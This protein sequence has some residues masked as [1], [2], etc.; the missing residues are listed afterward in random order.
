[1]SISLESISQE[2]LVQYQRLFFEEICLLDTAGRDSFSV[3]LP[4]PLDR[5][6]FACVQ[7]TVERLTEE[8]HRLSTFQWR[9]CLFVPIDRNTRPNDMYE[10]VYDEL[11]RRHP[12][13]FIR[14]YVY[15]IFVKVYGGESLDLGIGEND[16]PIS[17]DDLQIYA[18]NTNYEVRLQG[19]VDLFNLL[20]SKQRDEMRDTGFKPKASNKVFVV[21][22]P[23]KELQRIQDANSD[24]I[25]TARA[26]LGELDLIAQTEAKLRDVEAALDRS[27]DSRV[28][29]EGPARSGKTVIAMNLLSRYPDSKM[30]L[31]NWYFYDALRDAFKIWGEMDADE[32]R[33][34]FS[35]DLALLQTVR[36][37]EFAKDSLTRFARDPKLLE[38]EIKMREWPIGKLAVLPK[39]IKREDEN[40][41]EWLLSN[42]T[43]SDAGNYVFVYASSTKT[44]RP[45]RLVKVHREDF[46]AKAEWVYDA[47][48]SDRHTR[49]LDDPDG[50]ERELKTLLELRKAIEESTVDELLAA[51]VKNTAD[52]LSLSGQR[53]FHHDR[54]QDEGLWVDGDQILIPGTDMIIC[55]EA[56]RLGNY[57]G[58]DEVAKLANRPG[59]LFLCGDDCQRLNKAGD[60]GILQLMQSSRGEFKT[61]ELPESVGIPAEVGML[62]RSLLGECEAPKVS[63]SF[64]VKLISNNDLALVSAFGRDPSYKK[65]YAIPNST[66]FYKREYTPGITRSKSSTSEC[67]NNC[68]DHCTHRFIPMLSQELGS[69]FKFF[70]AEAI[71]PNYALSAYELISR[72]V[73][74]VYLKIPES[75]DARILSAPLE[76]G[77]LLNSWIKRHLYVLMTR[78]TVQLVI[79][80]E[81]LGLYN[82]FRQICRQA[83][84]D[85]DI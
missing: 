24:V 30:L 14:S 16:S 15:V 65:H 12:S 82:H 51:L 50:N 34:L 61:L 1:M 21:S 18:W 70:C 47:S 57:K 48:K 42:I 44:L 29:L 40:G 7:D 77:E 79:N 62:V 49:K 84:L 67:T 83:G 33:K 74:S 69:K 73:E 71:M 43:K 39:W 32:I 60:L 28:L 23:G 6:H 19:K 26:Y 37:K 17:K 41:T 3:P 10:E 59:R 36:E 85:P 9:N 75:I 64:E 76:G 13:L 2:R 25:D 80:V 58:L 72:E 52:A 45:V 35:T 22:N 78:P 56:Q 31:M 46:T 4:T 8:T 81:N 5:V 63:S 53:F 55:D 68:D 11:R 38:C 54:R 27:D 66:D 20:S